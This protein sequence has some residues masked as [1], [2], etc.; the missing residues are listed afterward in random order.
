MKFMVLK[1]RLILHNVG[2]KMAIPNRLDFVCSNYYSDIVG[3]FIACP[4]EHLH[5][6]LCRIIEFHHIKST[7]RSYAS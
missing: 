4:K 3:Y 5:R 7:D 1:Y 6:T 2:R